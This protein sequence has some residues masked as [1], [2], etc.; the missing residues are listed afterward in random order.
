MSHSRGEYKV[1]VATASHCVDEYVLVPRGYSNN[2]SRA[3][4]GNYFHSR[5]ISGLFMITGQIQV[6]YDNSKLKKTGLRGPDVAHGPHVA[7][8]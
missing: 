3:V 5:A 4:V 1:S 7:P 6:K 8:S 2:I